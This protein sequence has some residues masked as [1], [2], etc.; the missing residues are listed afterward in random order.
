MRKKFILG[1]ALTTILCLSAS[2]VSFAEISV[3]TNAIDKQSGLAPYYDDTISRYGYVNTFNNNEIVIPAQ[4]YR[5]NAFFNG[6]AIV[7]LTEMSSDEHA[8][9]IYA[10]IDGA[11]NE[12]C[13]EEFFAYDKYGYPTNLKPQFFYFVNDPYGYA[14]YSIYQTN[15]GLV[16]SA[17]KY[18][19][20]GVVKTLNEFPP[21]KNDDGLYGFA[22]LGD[23]VNGSAN[24]YAPTEDNSVTGEFG[25]VLN[26]Y[27]L[28]GSL[29]SNGEFTT[30]TNPESKFENTYLYQASSAMPDSAYEKL[31]A[32]KTQTIEGW[33][34]DATG[35]WY[36]NADGSYPANT[37][38]EIAGKQYYFGA[39]GYM[40][41]D[42]V[43][44]DGYNVDSTGA[45]IE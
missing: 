23:F 37:W 22:R 6:Y 31:N 42:T 20:T 3:R 41:H 5:A 11:G 24:V 36:R 15:I 30:E 40:L 32:S 7:R 21:I 39:D 1:I 43:T 45:W 19:G 33:Q 8:Q 10:L 26:K 44:P 17:T 29:T 28:V 25:Q 27:R 18:D 16:Y 12:L 38:K 4:Y 34:Q 2:I 35:W 14:Y 9:N 13:R